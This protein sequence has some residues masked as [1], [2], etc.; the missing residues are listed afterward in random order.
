M[1]ISSHDG[2][3]DGDAVFVTDLYQLAM[4]AAYHYACYHEDRKT[5]GIFELFV[6]RF[7]P[8]RSYLVAAGIGQVIHFILNMKF[9]YNHISYLKS[10]EIFKSVPDDFF[11]Y[12]R[13]FKFTGDLWAGF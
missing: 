12:L 9:N 8:N 7:P 1:M 11:E 2:N 5:Q 3:K 4:A 6:R 10:L 13:R